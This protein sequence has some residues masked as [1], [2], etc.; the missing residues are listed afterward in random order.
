MERRKVIIVI[1]ALVGII[2]I[3]A[4]AMQGLTG[5]KPKAPKKNKADLKRHVKVEKVAYSTVDSRIEAS[6]RVVSSNA[7]AL[8]AEAAGNLQKGDVKLRKG[9]GFKKGDVLG[10]VYKDEFELALKARKSRFLKI[11]SNLLPDMK[12]DFPNSYGDFVQFFN[13]IDMSKELPDLPQITDNK[14]K[15]FLSSRDFLTE[16]YNVLKDEKTLSRYTLRAPFNGVFSDVKFE[17]GAF[18]NKGSQ[19]AQMIRTNKIEIEVPVISTYS[20]WIKKGDVVDLFSR[21]R[22]QKYSGKVIYKAEFV[23]KGTQAQ[24]IFVKIDQKDSKALLAG[25]YLDVFFNGEPVDN[26]MEIPR[27]AVFNFNEIF[28]VENDRL[29]KKAIEI[30]KVNDKTVLIRGVE[31]GTNMVT[32]ALI[33]ARE[34]MPVKMLFD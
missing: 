31:V 10:V 29:K 33:N 1:V 30:V 32:Q 12:I 16:Y 20:R 8:I 27:S 17:V 14:L 26:V 34:N 24:S 13:S 25:E 11:I 15:V 6:G 9:V 7:V 4:L 21:E 22:H 5:M 28:I 3:G 19:V 18:V 23:D 2:A